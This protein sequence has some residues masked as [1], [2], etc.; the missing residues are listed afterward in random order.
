MAIQLQHSLTFLNSTYSLFFCSVKKTSTLNW[1]LR[2]GD[3]KITPE[4][5]KIRN[6]TYYISSESIRNDESE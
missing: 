3:C 6:L 1:E 2:T 4:D 5:K